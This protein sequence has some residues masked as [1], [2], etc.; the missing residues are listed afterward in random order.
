MRKALVVGIDDYSQAP[1]SG[2]VNDA[3]AIA[4]LLRTDENRDPNFHCQMLTAPE[5]TISKAS[6]T[7]KIDELFAYE[8]DVALFYF[9]GHGTAN[10][11]GGYLVTPDARKYS[12]GVPMSDLLT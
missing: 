7:Q 8:A 5:Q 9:S 12:E 10:N 3:N 11:L 1:L 4:S 2:C 6:L